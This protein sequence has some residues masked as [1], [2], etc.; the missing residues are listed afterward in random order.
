MMDSGTLTNGCEAEWAEM[1]ASAFLYARNTQH[2]QFTLIGPNNEQDNPAQD[3]GV[4]M[5]M[6]QYASALH[7]LAQL[8]DT[9]GLS[10]LRFV[11]PDLAY[12]STDW[13][14]AMMDDPVIMAKLAH[15]GLH[16][17]Y[18]NGD[19]SEGIAD[20]LRQSP[21][22]DRTYWMTEFN[23]WCSD[24]NGSQ[25]DGDL[26]D[27]AS[28]AARHLLYHLAYGASA[29]LAWEGYDS[30]YYYYTYP[31][32]WSFWGLF[33]VDDI[34]AEPRTYTPRKTFYT[35]AQISNFVRPGARQ[36]DVSPWAGPLLVVAFYHPDSGQLTLTGV[37]SN[38]GPRTLSGLLTNLPPVAGFDLYYTD[39]TTNLCHSTTLPVT[40]RSFTAT[41]PADCVFTLVGYGVVGPLARIN[42]MP[43]NATVAPYGSQ[44]FTAVAADA[45]G[46]AL[47]PQPSF[48]WSAA[49]GT[50]DA[51]GLFTAG[52]KAGGPFAVTASSGGFT[53]TA[54]ISVAS[55]LNLALAG[56]G[57]TWYTLAAA[58]DNEPQASAPGLNDGDLVTDVPLVPTGAEDE[59]KV[60][61]AAGV[62][63]PTTQTLNR[64]IYYN[65]S[66]TD[67]YDG[68]F[69]DEFCLQFTA[70]GSTW[71]NAGPAWTVTPP[72][73]YNSEVSANASFTFAGG[74]AAVR[75]VRCV[76]R[77]HT[78]NGY[79]TTNSWLALATEVQAFAPP[80]PP[81]PM[82][83]A[84]AAP[85]GITLSWPAPSTSYLLE[86][87]TDLLLTNAWS[88]VTNPPQTVGDLLT[89]T[90]P[91]TDA[92]RFFRLHQQ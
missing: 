11:G 33:A 39:S 43:A 63:W 58:T 14:S 73:T 84:N 15:F 25:G 26:W 89:V 79:G 32:G 45:R 80:P 71:T 38:A 8:L 52:G 66:Y 59:E 76:G 78:E 81:P 67:W 65:G 49:G 72:Y 42:L 2:L 60:Y 5:N 9:N 87:A 29:A 3:Q 12:T 21:Y 44:R 20:F 19:G 68:V 82:L 48:T 54:N 1:V 34:N 35:L 46:A 37:N 56:V 27:Y 74:V 61:E 57:Y 6:D 28:G 10:D 77:V 31:E 85:G 16:S 83:T 41:V 24:C 47:V 50:I 17:Y 36:I 13:L 23:V 55:N 4:N 90:V 18:D 69:A 64:V 53:G 30:Q 62:I 91:A 75:G 51:N 22:P 88:P 7:T 86:A 70:D 92:R 40:D